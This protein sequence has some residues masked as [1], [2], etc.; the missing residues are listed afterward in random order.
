MVRVRYFLVRQ[1]SKITLNFN[2]KEYN[3]GATNNWFG[4]Q[5]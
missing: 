4:G 5:S 3:H 1:A 2:P